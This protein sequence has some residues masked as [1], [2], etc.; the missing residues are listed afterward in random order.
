MDLFL[1][2]FAVPGFSKSAKDMSSFL[3]KNFV[4]D[5]KLADPS[6]KISVFI[7]KIPLRGTR[8]FTNLR[9]ASAR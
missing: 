9:A 8:R 2:A 4:T 1:Q 7:S 5:K 6:R 3:D